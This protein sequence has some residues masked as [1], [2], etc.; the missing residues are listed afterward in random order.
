MRVPSPTLI[1][2]AIASLALSACGEKRS[3]ESAAVTSAEAAKDTAGPALSPAVAPGVA[4]RFDYAFTLPSAAISG[5]QR[6]HAAACAKLG[7]SR[8]RVTGMNYEQNGK[9]NASAQLSFLLAPDI[10][11]TFASDSVAAVEQAEGKLETAQVSGENADA[12]IRLSQS[13]SAGIEAE[14]KRIEARLAAPGLS[15]S[16]RTELQSQIAALREQLRGKTQQRQS[17]E[18]SIATTPVNFSYSSESLIAGQGTFGKAVGASWSSLQGLLAFLALVGGVA[19][20]W[21]AVAGLVTLAWRRLRR[22]PSPA[23]PVPSE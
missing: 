21:L 2:I 17:L 10:A 16:E 12:Q 13:E 18:Q 8:C 23:M 1:T 3:D 4:F 6:E 9:D 22:K 19:L 11:Q 7:L 20:P 15:A 5:V 14:A